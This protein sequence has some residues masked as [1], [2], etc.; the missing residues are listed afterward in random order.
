MIKI[1]EDYN[2]AKTQGIR[3]T[4]QQYH[5]ASKYD[6][7]MIANEKVL[8]FKKKSHS[9]QH[10]QIVPSSEYYQR[11]LESHITTGHGRRDKIA[12][13]LKEKY[14][15]IPR[16]AIT[17]FIKLCKICLTTKG[18]QKTALTVKPLISNFRRRGQVDLMDLQTFPDK[19]YK[20]L[21]QYQ[22]HLTRFCF[23]RPLKSKRIK[24]VAIEL[25]KIFLEV[26]CPNILQSQNGR[27]YTASVLKEINCLWPTCKMIIGRSTNPQSREDGKD[28][29]ILDLKNMIRI[30]MVDNNST[31]WSLGCYLVQF[32]R[33]SSNDSI[34]GKTPY[35]AMFGHNSNLGLPS[36][37]L[38]KHII[39]KLETEE[40]LETYFEEIR[41]CVQDYTHEQTEEGE[42]IWLKEADY[43][44]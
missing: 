40:D 44:Y 29:L 15:M 42:E 2:L 38:P 31:N 6:V 33:N 16:F 24:E 22:D 18:F 21:M 14:I 20:W 13:V 9:D 26:G 4:G 28:N 5:H 7:A 12:Q 32:Q 8:I 39:S 37:H 23:L 41:K 19:D 10:V 25:L 30:W 17:I 43:E 35:R 36:T 11:L 3:P 34:I 1:I 27:E